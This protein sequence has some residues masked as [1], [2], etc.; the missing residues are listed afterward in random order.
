MCF[1]Q[2]MKFDRMRV[3]KGNWIKQSD[4]DEIGIGI[5]QIK[6]FISFRMEK[7]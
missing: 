3:S 2:Y 5:I 1:R 4:E 6:I 7:F